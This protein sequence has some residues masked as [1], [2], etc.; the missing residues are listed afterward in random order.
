MLCVDDVVR[1]AHSIN[2]KAKNR[3]TNIRVATLKT[4]PPMT[5]FAQKMYE[6]TRYV[7]NYRLQIFWVTLFTLINI[8]IFIERAHCESFSGKR[9]FRFEI[10]YLNIRICVKILITYID[11]SLTYTAF[12]LT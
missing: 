1:R 7:E 5:P 6:F 9:Y 3:Q 2:R 8:G 12:V 11:C 4:Q 10:L